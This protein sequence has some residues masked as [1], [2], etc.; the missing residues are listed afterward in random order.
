MDEPIGWTWK[1]FTKAQREIIK[2]ILDTILPEGNGFPGAGQL[3]VDRY[4][5]RIA[6]ESPGMKNLFS[7][8]ISS[9]TTL[10]KEKYGSGFCE[11]GDAKKTALLTELENTDT[12]FFRN[13]VL[14]TYN[15]Y[16]TDPNVLKILDL[17][18]RAPQ[19]QGYEL[20]SGDISALQQVRSRGQI[21][22]EA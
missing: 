19:P 13:L 12:A 3:G 18:V 6:G 22:R 11:L 9:L 1:F 7:R 14:H 5:D 21:Y 15:G 2:A 10:S 17:D 16:Y 4:L 8:G 20:E